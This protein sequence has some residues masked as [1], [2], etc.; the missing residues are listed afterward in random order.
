MGKVS[1]ERDIIYGA[2]LLSALF[3]PFYLP[4]LGLIL[5][6]TL[7]YLALLPIAYRLEI[8]IV[9]YLFTILIPTYLIRLYRHYQGW[10]LIELGHRERRMVPYVI[11]I[12]CYLTCVTVLMHLNVFRFVSSII[13]SALL[14]QM[15]CALINIKWKISTHMSAIGGVT[16]ALFAF[17]MIFGFNPVW[18][19]C[20]VFIVAGLLGTARMILRQ[21]SLSQVIGGFA[22]GF[23]CAS[24]GILYF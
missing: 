21:H 8:L 1:R 13:M 5:L 19:F 15:V 16:G 7:S 12:A 14:V 18:W 6:F 2:R 9:V 20:V 17:S 11:S 22:V 23:V 24:V 10:T 4:L 3:T